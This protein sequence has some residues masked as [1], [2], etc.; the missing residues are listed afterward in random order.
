M[1]MLN[2]EDLNGADDED[3][4]AIEGAGTPMAFTGGV[5]TLTYRIQSAIN[6]PATVTYSLKGSMLSVTV[7]SGVNTAQ[8]N[9]MV[10]MVEATDDNNADD[11]AHINVRMNGPPTTGGPGSLALV[12]GT[13]PVASPVPEVPDD[14]EDP[15]Y[16]TTN[17][18]ADNIVCD[19]LNRCLVKLDIDD[20]N[21]QDDHELEWYPKDATA[22]GV[23]V[24]ADKTGLIITGEKA[25]ATAVTLYVWAVDEDGLPGAALEEDDEST[26]ERDESVVPINARVYEFTIVVDGAP[27]LGGI[28]IEPVTMDVDAM[29]VVAT[30]FDEDPENLDLTSSGHDTKVV[31]I[32]WGEDTMYD[33][34]RKIQVTSYNSTSTTSGMVKVIEMVA[35]NNPT[36]YFEES[37][38]ATVRQTP[39]N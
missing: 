34:G 16:W 26:T 31:T 14:A 18:D 36:Q 13:Q 3:T 39:N 30:A 2:L 37:F 24:N 20:P 33:D 1:M 29:E 4:D 28:S 8:A 27:S 22:F 6:V 10:I 25:L 19:M 7:P 17:D 35:P 32:D 11:V 5:G 15:D 12:V 23:K 38:T 9:D 21:L